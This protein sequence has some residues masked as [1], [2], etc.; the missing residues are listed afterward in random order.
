M[1]RT[2]IMKHSI[3]LALTAAIALPAMAQ[4][5]DHG[6]EWYLGMGGGIHFSK[7]IYTDLNKAHF[8]ENN[9]NFSGVYSI[10]GE[11]DFG[12]E[13]M[14]AVRPQFSF[15]TRGGRLSRIG[16]NYY[17][18]YNPAL[19]D[20]E[21]LEDV[22]FRLKSTCFD[23]R[24]PFMYQI[25]KQSW[26]VR[27][28]VFIA[29]I[30]SI[31]D[32]GAISITNEYADGGRE[33]YEYDL[34]NANM[35][36][37]MFSGAIGVGAKWQFDVNGNNFFIG[38]D[39]SYE[40]TFTNTYGKGE[41]NGNVG[42]VTLYPGVYKV[43]GGRRMHGFEVNASIGIPLSVFSGKKSA[44]VVEEP[45][46]QETVVKE[47]EEVAEPECYSLEEISNL[48]ALGRSV[49]GKKIC[50]IDDINFAFN[51]SQIQ[52]SSY[53]YLNQL[54]GML[55]KT[56]SKVV[57]IG[58]TDN[59]G[60]DE[61]NLELSKK[62]AQAVMQYLIN[63]GVDRNRLSYRYYGMRRPISDN[64]TEEGRRMNRRVEF[65]ILK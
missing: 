35:A 47:P 30:L 31:V 43:S 14:F 13:N 56:D 4:H 18:G 37:V 44:P 21:R 10:F 51:K 2:H 12:R 20:D 54:A 34:T 65:E 8:P 17:P 57:I 11:F 6:N 33:G 58:H 36:S 5:Q 26:K 19:N 49:A 15:L 1:R 28:Y 24:V 16:E 7:L 3:L 22:V 29:P 61:F 9:S 41:K 46:Y 48:I 39:V 23:I 59:V 53:K 52:S 64:D 62:R 60:G 38:L 55:N 32:N 25:G 63:K 27:P 40:H 42:G 45:V 50:A